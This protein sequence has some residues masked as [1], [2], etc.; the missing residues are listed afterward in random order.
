MGLAY[1]SSS[2]KACGNVTDFQ[3]ASSYVVSKA[4]VSSPTYSFQSE[5]KLYFIRSADQAIR[6]NTVSDR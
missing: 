5:S 4:V 2:L 6:G 3:A 1:A